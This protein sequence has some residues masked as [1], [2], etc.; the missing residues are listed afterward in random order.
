VQA[1]G[2]FVGAV[3]EAL[4]EKQFA[5][6]RARLQGARSSPSMVDGEE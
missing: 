1:G 2:F 5:A 4:V 3:S 6:R